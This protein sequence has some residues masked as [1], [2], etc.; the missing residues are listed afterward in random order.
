[1]IKKSI[2]AEEML[3]YLNGLIV[4]DRRAISTLFLIRTGCNES[5]ENH[6]TVQVSD[7]STVGILGIIN[8]MFGVNKHGWGPFI[9]IADDDGPTAFDMSPEWNHSSEG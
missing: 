9:L 3:H 7:D 6:P 5:L 2:T 8:G 4:L 1:M